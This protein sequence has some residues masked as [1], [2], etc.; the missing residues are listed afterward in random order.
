MRRLALFVATAVTAA[1]AASCLDDRFR[2]PQ[3]SPAPTTT[4]PL[5]GPTPFALGGLDAGDGHDG[6]LAV[7]SG[8]RVVNGCDRV[9]SGS[10]GTVVVE[11]TASIAAGARLIVL[12]VQD[13][14]AVS[15]DPSPVT[16]AANAGRWDVVRAL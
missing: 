13:Q 14:F 5:P 6:P 3:A 8:V 4:T 1:C 10:N 2:L 16:S 7:T 12:Q 11:G 9:V 15:G